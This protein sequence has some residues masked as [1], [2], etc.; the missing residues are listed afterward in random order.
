VG[1]LFD[2]GSGVEALGW[3]E[4]EIVLFERTLSRTRRCEVGDRDCQNANGLLVSTPVLI[5]KRE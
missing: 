2:L 1:V 4:F 5:S 3:C